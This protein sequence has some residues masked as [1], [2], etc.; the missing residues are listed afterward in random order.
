MKPVLIQTTDEVDGVQWY[1]YRSVFP[2][3]FSVKEGKREIDIT[4][5]DEPLRGK[6]V[7]AR[8]RTFGFVR[9][10]E[11]RT[12]QT[13]NAHIVFGQRLLV[14]DTAHDPVVKYGKEEKDRR[15]QGT[16]RQERNDAVYRGWRRHCRMHGSKDSGGKRI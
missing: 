13:R 2:I 11:I 12:E 9:G 4:L 15:R 14:V 1:I 8:L 16:V 5:S 10:L 6:D 3:K 7:D